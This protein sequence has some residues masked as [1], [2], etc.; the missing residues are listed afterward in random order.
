MKSQVYNLKVILLAAGKS[1]RFNGIKLLAKIQQQDSSITLLEHAIQQISTALNAMNM[2]TE[3][4]RVTT[5]RFHAQITA[6]FADH[7]HI[8]FVFDYCEDAHFGLG[9]TIAQ[10][11]KQVCNDTYDAE[12]NPSHIMIALADQVALNPDDYVA[13][14]KQSLALPNKLLCA[15]AGQALMPPAIF[16]AAYFSDLMQLK[17][18]K[19]AKPILYANKDNL[20]TLSIPHAERD[21][22]TQQDLADWYN[23]Q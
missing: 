4:I 12:N 21:I 7:K 1:E 18:D 17:G 10:S 22:D 6:S 23:N 19:G 9:H 13:L 15:Q 11:V 2:K 3:S 16:P 8:Q 14:I 5:G 20:E